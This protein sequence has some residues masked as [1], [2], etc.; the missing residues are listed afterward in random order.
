MEEEE[1]SMTNDVAARPAAT[2]GREPTT[3]VTVAE[4]PEYAQAEAA[5]DHLSDERFPVEQVRIV[6]YGLTTV[7]RV[8]GRLTNRKAASAGAA[9]GAWVGLLLGLLL[10]LF[11]PGVVWVVV[12]LASSAL[13]AVWGALIGFV[14]HWFTR[15][16]RDFASLKGLAAERYA[17]VVRRENAADAARLLA[18]LSGAARTT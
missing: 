7:E 18:G 9:A 15:G 13:S 10:G 1:K 16:R 4:Y 6:G 17:L 12:L 2:P 14:A 5:V 3:G 11:M 8:T